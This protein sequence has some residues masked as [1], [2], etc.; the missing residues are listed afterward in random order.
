MGDV[1]KILVIDDD[2][3]IRV[4]ASKLL[5]KAGHDIVTAENGEIGMRMASRESP[6]LILLDIMMPGIDGLQVCSKLKSDPSTKD[7]IVFMLTGKTQMQDIEEALSKGADNYI[8]KPINP[9]KFA[10]IVEV[11]LKK[12]PVN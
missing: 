2:K 5:T 4:M 10:K 11:K 12:I 9:I 6:D 7:I 1:M 8:A 3:T